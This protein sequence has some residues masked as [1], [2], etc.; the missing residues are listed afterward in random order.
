MQDTCSPLC[1]MLTMMPPTGLAA[2]R[3]CP[4]Y[5]RTFMWHQTSGKAWTINIDSKRASS[6]C[7][8]LHPNGPHITKCSIVAGWLTCW[9]TPPGCVLQSAS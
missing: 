6:S 2:E 8:R 1:A 5:P 7:P 4:A 3:P 9:L